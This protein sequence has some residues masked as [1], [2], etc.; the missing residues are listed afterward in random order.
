MNRFTRRGLF[1]IGTATVI[2]LSGY[3]CPGPPNKTATNPPAVATTTGGTETKATPFRA[4]LVFDTGGKD[5]KSFNAGANAGLERAR[6]E[7]GLG[8]DGIKT[9]ESRASADYKTNLTNFASQNYDIVIAVGFNMADAIKDVS[10]QFPNTKF[11]IVDSDAPAN[12]KNVAGLR[13]QEEQG[14]FLAGYL[15]AMMSKKHKIGFV[16]G[17]K[18]PLIEK[19]EAGYKAGAKTAGLDPDKQVYASYVGDW[20]DLSKGKSQARLQFDQGADIVFQAAGKAG[21]AVITEAKDRGAGYYAIG[22][23]QDQDYIAPGRVLTSMVK[24]VD[25]AVFDTIKMAKDGKFTAGDHVFAMKD[26]GVG[27][28]DLKYTRKD[29]PADV[30]V[31]LDKLTKLISDG[32]V[33][34]P[35]TLAALA[36]FKPPV[37]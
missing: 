34:P 6:T 28:S 30:L 1:G 25:T 35:A 13:F 2:A 10:A 3:G 16:G 8:T 18:I 24:H 27:I 32:T 20:D 23:D 19:F 22:V 33:V 4:A 36:T 5:D 9:V 14:S 17:M 29:I 15:A 37:L 21:L 31:K 7:L 26:G 12:S 11:A